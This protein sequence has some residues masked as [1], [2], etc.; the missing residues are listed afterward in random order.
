MWWISMPCPC[1]CGCP[2][3]PGPFLLHRPL[4]SLFPLGWGELICRGHTSVGGSPHLTDIWMSFYSRF[5]WS[6]EKRSLA[7]FAHV[8]VECLT[9]G[10]PGT[11][12]PLG[13]PIPLFYIN[14]EDLGWYVTPGICGLPSPCPVYGR[15]SSAQCSLVWMKQTENCSHLHRWQQFNVL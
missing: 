13:P 10:L 12:G 15:N 11:G 2:G 6:K 5:S 7:L 14:V 1:A 8:K 4:E 3:A 9:E